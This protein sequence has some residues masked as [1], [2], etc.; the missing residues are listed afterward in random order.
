MSRN[1]HRAGSGKFTGQWVTCDAGIQCKLGGT[2]TQASTLQEAKRWVGK[3]RASDV[4]EEDYANFLRSKV[5]EAAT[6]STPD[7]A[8]SAKPANMS[9]EDYIRSLRQKLADKTRTEQHTVQATAA[10]NERKAQR[11]SQIATSLDERRA[12][13]A[14]RRDELLMG[15][16]RDEKDQR[17]ARENNL[18]GLV[19]FEQNFS[20]RTRLRWNAF[21]ET[22][23]EMGVY[24]PLDTVKEAGRY[25]AQGGRNF[26]FKNVPLRL[27]ADKMDEF[28]FKTQNFIQ[29]ID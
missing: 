23:M 29:K 3:K 25:F 1:M 13:R 14:Q 21:H 12:L 15:E 27:K 9:Q 17:Y 5:S 16:T 18:D 20:I 28:L 19:P 6:T 11:A 8:T 2:H 24:I 4:T 7:Q 22:A 26:E 10:L